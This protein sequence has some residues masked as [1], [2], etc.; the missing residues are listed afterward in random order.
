[1]E[2]DYRGT[3]QIPSRFFFEHSKTDLYFNKVNLKRESVL[4]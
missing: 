4:V 1:M 3:R 2:Q